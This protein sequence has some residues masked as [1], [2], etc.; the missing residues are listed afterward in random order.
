MININSLKP[1]ERFSR[2][3]ENYVK[4]RPGYPDEIIAYLE[5][6]GILHKNYSIADIGSGTGK[7]AELFLRH[8]YKV[9]AVEPNTRMRQAAE[10]L[11]KGAINFVSL[12]GSAEAIPLEDGSMDVV[13]VGQAF[14]WFE[15][16]TAV[17]E[18]KRLLRNNGCVVLVWNNRDVKV[19]A[20]MRDYEQLLQH[21]GNDY[22]QI[23]SIYYGA[24]EMRKIFGSDDVERVL[25]DYMQEFD[26]QGL[27]GRLESTS[28]CPLPG[29]EHYALI[30]KK[31][32]ELFHKHAIENKVKITYK[33]EVAN[34][35]CGQEGRE[36]ISLFSPLLLQL[37]FHKSSV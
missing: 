19:S 35:G 22:K 7:L 25:F 4:Y 31:L 24:R 32:Q 27:K 36:Q 1:K 34:K 15:V 37:L 18:F 9:Y 16:K 30:I 2:R 29:T 10:Q 26:F 21:Y 12:H 33:T 5:E 13:V 6:I 8:G 23:R 17:K 28:Y 11:F 20:C 3:V 14:H